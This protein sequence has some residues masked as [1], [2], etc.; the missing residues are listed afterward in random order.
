MKEHASRVAAGLTLLGVALLMSSSSGPFS[1]PQAGVAALRGFGGAVFW[2]IACR[3]LGGFF[4]KKEGGIVQ[5]AAGAG[6]YGL[7]LGVISTLLGV[8]PIL[9]LAA[10]MVGVLLALRQGPSRFPLPPLY[11]LL[12]LAAVLSIGLVDALAPPVDTDEVYQH[13]A[14]PHQFL[15]EG[16]LLS[17]ELHPD[18]SRPLPVHM[19][20]TALLSFGGASA[21]KIFHLLLSG[22]LL[23]ALWEVAER[24][25][26][27][28]SGLPCILLLIGSYSFVREI[29]LAYNNLPVALWCLLAL[30]SALDNRPKPMAFFSGMA[31]AAKYTAA[32]VLVGIY[33]AW[34]VQKRHIDLSG[35][36]QWTAL[37][38]LWV[39]PWWARNGMDGLHP[40]FPYAGWDLESTQFMHLEK[41]G[42]GR[43]VLDLVLLPWNVS[44][45]AEPDS[46]VFL[47]RLSPA[48]LLFLPAALILGI[49]QH[50]AL[51]V[52]ALTAFVGWS[53]G[54]HWIRYLLPAAP[55][56]A[57]LL[58]TGSPRLPRF[59]QAALL[60]GV[61]LGLP[62][63]WGPWLSDLAERAPTVTSH[64]AAEELLRSEI[65]G[66]EAIDWINDNS[67]EDA[68]VALLFSWP[69]YHVN[70]STVLG[71]VEDHVPTRAHLGLH[72]DAA[73][74]VLKRSNVTHLIVAGACSGCKNFLKKSYP[75]LSETE[76]REHYRG[77]EEQLQQLLTREATKV[78][79]S[80]KYS[81]WRLL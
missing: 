30:D 17:G 70:R 36:F 39:L 50:K 8:F 48:G 31:L 46:F 49:R 62:R 29:G 52:A 33:L 16:H 53:L 81:V 18:A 51:A 65:R 7:L 28:H 21:A 20:Y 57:L 2:A 9:F 1:D 35:L 41:Y 25:I 24:R 4:F 26:G 71:S 79:E 27:E 40:L 69:K 55:I 47:G 15:L 66:Y 64:D 22:L 3:G 78:F 11:I 37:A 72:N 14:L 76:F 43:E 68:R 10:G 13:L 80:S 74:Q 32:P 34:V 67:P 59:A 58:V 63:N 6:A 77:P 19:L 54:P 61:A 75:F 38:L 56:L 45:H 23:W 44:V 60:L 5:F 42:M 73:L 12:I